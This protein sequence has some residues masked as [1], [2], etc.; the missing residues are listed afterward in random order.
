M[1]KNSL[2]FF[3]AL[4]LCLVAL[5]ARSAIFGQTARAIAQKTSPSVVLLLMN[6]AH[7][8]PISL[9]SGFFVADGVIATNLHVIEGASS[10]SAKSIGQRRKTQIAG[11]VAVDRVND[12]AL[13]S[14]TGMDGPPIKLGNSDGAAVGDPVFAIGNPEGLEGTL[15]EGIVS[16]IRSVGSAKLLQITAAISPGSSGGPVLN[17]TGEVI[18]VAVSTLI[19]GQSLNFAV[20]SSFLNALMPTIH[21]PAPFPQKEKAHTTRSRS[22]ELETPSIQGISAAHFIWEHSDCDVDI[23]LRCRFSFSLRNEMQESVTSVRWI[24]VF[25]D[26]EGKPIDVYEPRQPASSWAIRA[27][28]AKRVDGGYIDGAVRRLA[29]RIQIRIL[30]FTVGEYKPLD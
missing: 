25:L 11:V 28:L 4:L 20:P 5:S 2:L 17:D 24:I 3:R 16:G 6:D 22:P 29:A 23:S 26:R 13:I 8:N 15:S 14:V 27:G 18:G 21:A 7:G 12:L 30:D 19:S 10:G 1:R 9:G